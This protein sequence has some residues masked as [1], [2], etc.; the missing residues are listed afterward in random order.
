MNKFATKNRLI[1]KKKIRRIYPD[2]KITGDWYVDD[3]NGSRFPRSNSSPVFRSFRIIFF[4]N[5]F[6]RLFPWTC[7][8]LEF[9]IVG[10]STWTRS[11]VFSDYLWKGFDGFPRIEWFLNVRV[12]SRRCWRVVFGFPQN[13]KCVGRGWIEPVGRFDGKCRK[14]GMRF[15]I[16]LVINCVLIWKKNSRVFNMYKLVI[17]IRNNSTKL[18]TY[19]FKVVPFC[20]V[21]DVHERRSLHHFWKLIRK[22]STLILPSFDVAFP[23]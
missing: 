21:H 14:W 19:L 3:V 5:M 8:N 22:S 2:A 1:H 18:I 17:F 23:C 6:S 4:S 7:R 12:L 11:H 20:I 10:A 15:I 16:F 9:H 13:L